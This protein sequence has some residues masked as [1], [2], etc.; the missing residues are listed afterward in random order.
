[1][2]T[3]LS[4]DVGIK[5]LSYCL[6]ETLSSKI[7]IKEWNNI[8]VTN[9]NCKKIKLDILTECI[10]TTL[11]AYFDDSL[12]VDVIL[13]ENQPM[14]KNGMMKTVSV[15]IYTYFNMLR[16]QYG[17]IGEVRFISASNKLKCQ[18]SIINTKKDNYKDRKLLSINIAREY[19]QKLC[20]ERYEWF[21]SQTKKDDCADSLNQGLYYIQ[22]VLNID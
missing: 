14:L 19:I 8:S 17:N 11:G 3:I 7:T 13:I 2:K 10:L 18:T 1:M 21:E 20:P 9:A 6:L 15:I 5:N 16:L 22:N 4:I 12:T